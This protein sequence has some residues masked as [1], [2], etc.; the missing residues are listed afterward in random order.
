ML[1]EYTGDKP[2]LV[3]GS[4]SGSRGLGGSE[5]ARGRGRTRKNSYVQR[6]RGQRK[7][8]TCKE[9]KRQKKI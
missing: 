1:S 7:E 2:N 3:L 6:P 4:A 5:L 8:A 9:L